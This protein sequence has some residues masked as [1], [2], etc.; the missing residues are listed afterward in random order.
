MLDWVTD[1]PVYVQA[2]AVVLAAWRIAALL[3]FEAGPLRLVLKL[4]EKL[5]IV[6][7]EDGYPTSWPE[8]TL[9]AL[10][11]CV[12]CMSLWTTILAYAI[13]WAAPYLVIFVATWGGATF[14]EALRRR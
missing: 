6:H 5:G 3:V 12:W 4:R 7:N 11:G 10:F 13:L 8:T 2:P 1:P 9:A 14:L